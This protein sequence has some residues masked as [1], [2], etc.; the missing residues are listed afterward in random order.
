M[1]VPLLDIRNVSKA[2]GA[3]QALRNVSLT[4]MPGEVHAI[5]GE[6][7]AGKSTLIN[8]VSGVVK[9]DEGEISFEGSVPRIDSPQAAQRLGIATVHQEL[10]LAELLTVAENIFAARLPSRHGLVDRTSLM[11]GAEAVLSALGLSLDPGQRVG[12]LPLGSRQLVEIAKA[13][14]LDA[15]LLLLDEPTSALNANEKD[16]LFGLVRRLSRLKGIGI[17]YISHHLNEITSLADRITV[18]RDGRVVSTHQ[19]ESIT[20]DMLVHEMVGRAISR[21]ADSGIHQIGKPLL[22]ARDLS[23]AGAFSDVNFTIHAGEII[24]LVGLLGSGRS[25]LASCLAG[26]KTPRYGDIL[27]DDK[28][29]K[30]TSLRHA[31]ALGIGYVPPE[32][33][34][35]GLFLELSLGDNIASASLPKFSAVGVFDERKQSEMARTYI[36]SLNIRSDGPHTRCAALSGGNQQKVLLAKWL[37]TKPRLLIVEEPTKGVDI[38]SKSEIHSRL[39]KLAANGTAILFVSTDLP[40][41]LALSHRI[42]V[43]YRENIA[44]VLTPAT[45]NEQKI[46]AFA[47]GLRQ[48]AA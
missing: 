5:V 43:M 39:Q 15:R 33:K 18:L 28:A 40:E 3:T 45:A 23:L 38:A 25:A 1:T 8:V 19:A 21:R 27:I 26:L 6:N 29:V 2:Y 9:P 37:E 22:E 34:T 35:D 13:L 46:M 30:L 14:S 44:A 31:K 47:S 12:T 7:G 16:A 24:S 42:L 20:A 32:R 48:E 17:I 36:Q 4:V 11:A 41:I 10:S